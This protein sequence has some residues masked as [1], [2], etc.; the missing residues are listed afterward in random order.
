MKKQIKSISILQ[1]SKVIAL[2][3]VLISLIYSF[4]GVLMVAFGSG[5]IKA[6]GA[7]YIFMPLLMGIIGFL[8]MLLCCWLYNVVAKWVGGIEFTV[9]EIE[10]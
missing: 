9:E 10:G 5:P 3:Y 8:M 7:I 1:T 6:M 4:I 2:F